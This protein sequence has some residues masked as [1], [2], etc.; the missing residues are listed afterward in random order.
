MDRIGIIVFL[1][2]IESYIVVTSLVDISG[3]LDGFDNVSWIMSSYQLGFVGKTS[4][5]HLTALPK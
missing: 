1:V 3:D 5:L 4:L 2:T